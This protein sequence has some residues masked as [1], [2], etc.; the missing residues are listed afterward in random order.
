[1]HWCQLVTLRVGCRHTLRS[2]SPVFCL[3]C[4]RLSFN[5][6]PYSY[7]VLSVTTDLVASV[8]RPAATCT[9]VTPLIMPRH[10]SPHARGMH[11]VLGVGS[12][13]RC[14]WREGHV[15]PALRAHMPRPY[16]QTKAVGWFSVQSVDS[17]QSPQ[18]EYPNPRPYP[19]RSCALFP[20]ESHV[21]ND[22]DGSNF[23][24]SVILGN[25]IFLNF[26]DA[27]S[28]LTPGMDH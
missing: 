16:I 7:A 28:L 26:T 23:H 21:R 6:S 5:T 3:S 11:P 19:Y 14:L 18:F 25:F 1:M 8:D 27:V 22:F 4:M 10:P 13:G 17:A 2:F 20:G 24:I 9:L 15:R 12:V